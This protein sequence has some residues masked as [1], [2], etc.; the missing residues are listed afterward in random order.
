MNPMAHIHTT[1]AQSLQERT[2]IQWRT[3][4]APLPSFT[5]L[6]SQPALHQEQMSTHVKVRACL[7]K[8]LPL[9]PCSSADLPPSALAPCCSQ[10]DGPCTK[11]RSACLSTSRSGACLKTRLSM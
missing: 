8:A 1:P 5:A 11:C 3:P 9:L 10:P 2:S 7:W 6:A 4:S